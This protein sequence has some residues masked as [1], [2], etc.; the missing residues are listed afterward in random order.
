[1]KCL[2]LIG[3]L[4]FANIASGQVQWTIPDGYKLMFAEVNDTVFVGENIMNPD[5]SYSFYLTFLDENG[6]LI[7]DTTDITSSIVAV[8]NAGVDN[9]LAGCYQ[10]LNDSTYIPQLIAFE[11]N[12]QFRFKHE[13][14]S[15]GGGIVLIRQY[16]DS[17]YILYTDSFARIRKLDAMGNFI[18]EFIVDSANMQIY[19]RPD[20]EFFGDRVY[21]KTKRWPENAIKC[22]TLDGQHIYTYSDTGQVVMKMCAFNGNHCAFTYYFDTNSK[23]E[24]Y[25]GLLDSTGSLKW[26]P[27]QINQEYYPYP[28]DIIG[29]QIFFVNDSLYIASDGSTTGFQ[30]RDTSN[31]NLGFYLTG[32]YIVGALNVSIDSASILISSQDHPGFPLPEKYSVRQYKNGVLN[33]IYSDTLAPNQHVM[34]KYLKAK[35]WGFY[36]GN[37]LE[38]GRFNYITTGKDELKNDFLM[39]PNPVKSGGL[40]H[41]ESVQDILSPGAIIIADMLGREMDFQTVAPGKL[42]SI[43]L[44]ELD[45][46]L[47][48]V[49]ITSGNLQETFRIMVE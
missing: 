49:I 26:P 18:T 39:Y 7:H 41:L 9:L 28:P 16:Q 32:M 8:M 17:I 38:F 34:A 2:I 37:A 27:V 30:A 36:Y 4:L 46:G 22:Y 12:G 11:P 35:P 31:G 29:Q 40:I 43:L 24:L 15:N 48:L 10:I 13:L 3:T 25:A 14:D 45:P 1:M 6:Q 5:S 42:K 33:L 23:Y 44:P 20:F 21:V 19:E 47:Y